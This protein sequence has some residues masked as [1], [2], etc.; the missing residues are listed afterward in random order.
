MSIYLY[1]FH[2]P[3]QR[4]THDPSKSISNLKHLAQHGCDKPTSHSQLKP[5]QISKRHLNYSLSYLPTSTSPKPNKPTSRDEH[6]GE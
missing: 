3:S 1:I 6:G 5:K 2:I 4:Q